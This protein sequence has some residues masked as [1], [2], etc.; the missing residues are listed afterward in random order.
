MQGDFVFEIKGWSQSIKEQIN[1]E[2][3]HHAV[4]T[5]NRQYFQ[6]MSQNAFLATYM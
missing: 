4:T 1:M 3:C 6:N 5:R 2:K